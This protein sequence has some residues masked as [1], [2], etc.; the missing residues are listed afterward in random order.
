M[1]I[2]DYVSRK[3]ESK[4][5]AKSM[6]NHKFVVK[7]RQEFQCLWLNIGKNSN[8]SRRHGE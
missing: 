5:M 1:E 3:R 8:V 7:Y 2:L 6:N 4:A